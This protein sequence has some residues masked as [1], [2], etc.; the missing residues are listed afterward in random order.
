MA[1]HI[2]KQAAFLL[3][4]RMDNIVGIRFSVYGRVHYCDAQNLDLSLGEW[5]FVEMEDGCREG[6]VVI[7]TG[8]VIHSDLRGPMDRVVRK[9]SP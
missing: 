8:Q 4:N 2:N 9:V 1:N 3:G 6:Y 5:V 7:E